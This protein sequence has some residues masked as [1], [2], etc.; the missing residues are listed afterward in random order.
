[1]SGAKGCL[2]AWT[3][4]ADTY[5]EYMSVTGVDDGITITMRARGKL[6]DGVLTCGATVQATMQLDV[7]RRLVESLSALDLDAR[8]D[9]LS[10][11]QALERVLRGKRLARTRWADTG[12]FI[13]LVAG[14][15]FKV[16]REPLLSI[17]GKDTLVNYHGHIDLRTD[18]GTIVPWQPNQ[19]DMLAN[20]WHEVAAP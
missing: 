7:V 8:T 6:V 14:S 1:M 2:F 20:D 10:F 19:P 13:F 12:M 9:N 17:L 16:N 18:T 5:P 4:H 3:A 15:Q 11:S